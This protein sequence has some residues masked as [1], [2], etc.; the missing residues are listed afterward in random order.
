[1]LSMHNE[2]LYAERALTAGARGYIMKQEAMDSV[3]GAVRLVLAGR[4]YASETV[5]DRIMNGLF[6]PAGDGK[7]P[8]VN[9]LTDR[10]LEVFRLI[11]RGLSTKEIAH[12]LN[13]S[14]KTIGTYRE[15]IKEKLRIKHATE[16]VQ[17]AVH[18]TGSGDPAKGT[19]RG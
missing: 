14:V 5:K 9:R 18:W 13:L 7:T 16:L 2:A 1:M 17:C 10:E 15:R 11:G 6:Q 3:V 19:E 12:T 4:I 8:A